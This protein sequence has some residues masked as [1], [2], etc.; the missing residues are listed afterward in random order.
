MGA[1]GSSPQ[2]DKCFPLL[3]PDRGGT[4]DWGA[5]A[6]GAGAR[7]RHKKAET[8]GLGGGEKKERERGGDTK[9]ER[10]QSP[11]TEMS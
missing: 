9:A 7:E 5:W 10:Q 11:E 1:G 2:Q 8:Q 3:Q 6:E 4:G